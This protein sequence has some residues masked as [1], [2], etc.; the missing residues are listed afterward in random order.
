MDTKD[1][2]LERM[3]NYEG[4]LLSDGAYN[5]TIGLTLLWGFLI[6]AGMIFFLSPYILKIH[7]GIM[8]ASYLVLSLGCITL[9][10]K[11]R[12]PALSFLGFT[13]L[14]VGMGLVITFIVSMYSGT[15]V[16]SAFLATGIIVVSMMIISTIK[17]AFFMSIGRSL[18]YA[19][20]G[21][22]AIELIGGLIFR[23]PLTWMDYVVVVIFAGFIGY[24]WAR[25]NTCAYTV[26]NAIDLSACLYLD[27]INLF[28]R[29]LSIVMRKN[30][31][32]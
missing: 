11:S 25:A 16:Y 26:N 6:N 17:P 32:D 15:T 12:K 30:D 21:S 14:A 23:M 22:I 18:V 19:L 28:L 4:M 29:I 3:K 9:V 31:R 24:D 13:G 27:I 1:Y 8:I 2:R 20:L 7:P 10:V 5:I